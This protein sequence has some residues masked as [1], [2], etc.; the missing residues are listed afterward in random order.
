MHACIKWRGQRQP[1]LAGQYML[2]QILHV[3]KYPSPMFR[4]CLHL[5]PSYIHRFHFWQLAT[6]IAIDSFYITMAFSMS[7]MSACLSFGGVTIPKIQQ[8]TRALHL[9]TNIQQLLNLA[10]M[11]RA[12]CMHDR[13]GTN[14][15]GGGLNIIA[16]FGP[17]GPFITADQILRDRPS[18]I[19]REI[20]LF[21]YTYLNVRT[22]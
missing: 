22:V 21:S 13:G 8:Q 18:E 19:N 1:V 9:L 6:C 17:G 10:N 20:N 11:C 7:K 5:A 16:I 12:S 14:F 4:I 15:Y 3:T 2:Q